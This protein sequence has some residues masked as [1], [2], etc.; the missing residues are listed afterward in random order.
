VTDGTPPVRSARCAHGRVR[1][2]IVRRVRRL[3]LLVALVSL[4]AACGSGGKTNSSSKGARSKATIPTSTKLGTGVSADAVKLGVLMVDFDC[5]SGVIDEARPDQE[6]A[7]RIY[8]ADINNKGG[9]NGRKIDPVIKTYCPLN[10]DT[11]LAACTSLT[12]DNN[13]FAVV[14]VF[15]DPSGDAQLCFSKRHK[16]IVIADSITQTLV[17]AGPPGFMLTPNISPER[18]LN[19]IMSLLE[20]RH[21]LDGKTV[22]TLSSTGNQRRVIDVVAPALKELGV[23][24]GTDATVSITGGDTTDA[25]TQLD[26]FIER[27]KG[28][29]TNAVI[30]VGAEVASKQFVE[31]IKK[32]IPE[33]QLVSDTTEILDA[34]REEQKAH[35]SPNPYDGAITAE[36]QTG[37]EH[38]KTEHFTYCRDIWEKATG[39]KVPSPNVVVRLANGKQDDIYSEV[40]DACLFTS[41]FA[42]IA[43]KV[44]PYLNSDNWVRTV[45]NFGP[46][47]DTSTLYASIHK[48]KYDADDTYGLVAYDPTIGDA[49]DWVHVTPVQNV[50]G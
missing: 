42:T 46:V 29:G 11:E 12:E 38:T 1:G 32:A 6:Q 4:V 3:A 35:V 31:K 5:L 25:L 16:T 10:L 8:I 44:G 36:G 22:G 20:S 37:I 27:W 18:R 2:R 17:D 47:D 21:T 9:I 19:V 14:G 41:F 45:D 43:R 40:E 13:V 30:L 15:Y 24:R 23:K 33:M 50:T 26:S 39:R 49:G 7:Y 48:G 34:G 28:D